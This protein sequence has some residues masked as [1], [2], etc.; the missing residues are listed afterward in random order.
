MTN[1]STWFADVNGSK[2]PFPY[3]ERFATDTD[4]AELLNVSTGAGKTATIILGWLWRR[5]FAAAEVRAQTPRRLVYCL[6]MRTL[7][8]QT[9]DEAQAWLAKAGLTEDVGLHLLMGGAV[10]DRWDADPE[11]DCILIGTQDQLLSRALNRGYSMSRYRWPIHFALLNNDCLWVFD[12]TQL[13]GASLRTSAQLQ[14]FREKLGTF[15][16]VRS[17]WV[18]ATLDDSQLETVDFRKP[19]R[20]I[21]LD[22]ED[23]ENAF[24]QK[25]MNAKKPIQKAETVFGGNE[26][27][28]GKAIAQ[29]IVAAH[30]A[31]ET[32]IVICNR[33]SRA[34]E[35]YRSLQKL[36]TE[37][38]LLL[39]HSRFRAAE[40]RRINDTVG[41]GEDSFKGIIV[42]TQAI[43]AGVDISARVMFSELAPWSSMVQ[44]VGRC[45]RYG[46]FEDARVFWIDFDL[47]KKGAAS[48]YESQDLEISREQLQGLT[49]IGRESIKDIHVKT[50]EAE[51]LIPRRSDLMQ[52]FDTS[53]DLA[54]H[55]IDVS[56]FIRESEEMDVAIAW[57]DWTDPQKEPPSDRSDPDYLGAIQSQEI[58]RV[59]L[60][61][62]RE[63]LKKID[64]PAWIF[65]RT[66]KSWRRLQTTALYPGLTVLLHSSVG[67]YS[68]TLG[69]TGEVNTTKLNQPVACVANSKDIT[70]PDDDDND[71]LSCAK[72]FATL[73]RHSQLTAKNVSELCQS[74][75]DLEIPQD[76]SRILIK[77][78]LWHDAGKAHPEFQQRIAF[79][80]PNLDREELWAKS[81]HDRKRNPDDRYNWSKNEEGWRR[82]FRHELVSALLALQEQQDFLLVYLVAAHHGKIRMLMQPRPFEKPPRDASDQEG[83]RRYALGVYEGDFVPKTLPRIEL[84]DSVSIPAQSLNLDCMELGQNFGTGALSWS[85]RA[86][87]LLEKWGP[88]KLAFLEM[89]IRIAD[90]RASDEDALK[91]VE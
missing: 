22:D 37:I 76:I 14:G 11:K 90:W 40:R 6:P 9:Y 46:E 41:K 42:A 4:L 21:E 71:T 78:G 86:L 20:R 69:F 47:E 19:D 50:I 3:Q 51:T 64:A 67:G 79:N 27:D 62:A 2:S 48:P 68:P 13:M 65:D 74:L 80:R 72:S 23:L 29:E 88:F 28:Y 24:L 38:P 55:D 84:D 60:Y 61:T 39:V 63:F 34:Q 66:Q 83:N 87:D 15:G 58:C 7:V 59:R 10:S 31:G 73:K 30:M 54:G 82:G 85:E 25:R 89:M 45:N 33:V 12:E 81:D 91:E 1:Y 26:K 43:E 16:T 57:R 44:R 77:S 53:V 8:E 70:N 52:L 17:L 18:S 36:K 49:D 32:T 56:P 5:R 75:V 35:V